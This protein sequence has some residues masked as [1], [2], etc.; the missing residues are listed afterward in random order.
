MKKPALL[1]FGLLLF[2]FVSIYFIIPEKIK[3]TQ[4]INIDATDV[5]VSRFLVNKRLWAKWW[6]GQYNAA[7]SSLYA[8]KGIRYT[9]KKSTNERIQVL[10]KTGDLEIDSWLNYLATEEGMTTVTWITEKQ[11][12]L[13][14]FTRIA[15][16]LKIKSTTGDLDEIL[17][18]FKKFMQKD[19]N[20]YGISV[21]LN[22]IK[23]PIV[24]ASTINSKTYPSEALIYSTIENL[25]QQIAAQQAKVVNYPIMNINHIDDNDYHITIALP[26]DRL[27]EPGANAKINKLVK[28]ANI[29]E[30]DVK[31]G[32]HTV[33]NAMMQLKKYQQDYRLISP[34][35][36]YE[37]L[38]SNR[39]TEKD[40]TKWVT[41]IYY[42][43]F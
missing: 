27:I 22:K 26:I 17:S 3:T 25:K 28:G 40:T 38:I 36:P 7:D 5:N 43:I 8:Y 20:V 15:G 29:L 18:H 9:L 35:M 37:Q 2:A 16:F 6:P 33:A 42:P 32:R 39:L 41:K 21:K 12:S 34:A 31:G 23:D 19:I 30:T 1:I 10:I 14:P 13:N 24:L 4:K 11:S